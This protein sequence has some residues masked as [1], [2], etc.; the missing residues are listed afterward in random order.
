MPMYPVPCI[1]SLPRQADGIHHQ[2]P[3]SAAFGVGPVLA[4]KERTQG[5][6]PLQF[7]DLMLSSFSLHL[8]AGLFLRLLSRNRRRVETPG[9]VQKEESQ[10]SQYFHKCNIPQLLALLQLWLRAFF[11]GLLCY[12]LNPTRTKQF[13]SAFEKCA[14]APGLKQVFYLNLR[15][16]IK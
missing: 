1:P 3:A 12:Y 2:R 8:L 11:F 13:E 4:G 5:S 16:E 9:V 7:R 10:L 14:V 6:L 15:H